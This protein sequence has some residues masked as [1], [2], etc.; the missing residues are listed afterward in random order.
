MPMTRWKI[1]LREVHGDVLTETPK[2]AGFF[3]DCGM[4]S[5]HLAYAQPR[6]VECLLH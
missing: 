5:P 2:T 1:E 6:R 3:L 4:L